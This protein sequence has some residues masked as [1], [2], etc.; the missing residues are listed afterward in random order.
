MLAELGLVGFLL[1]T[2]LLAAT[3]WAL[4]LVARQD[5]ALGVGLAAVLGALV[6]HSLLYAG[7][8]EDPLAWGVIGLAAAALARAPA[9]AAVAE[10]AT[11]TPSS[12]P[13]VLAH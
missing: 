8:F 10:R 12:T 3:G 6:V 7:F 9:A 4:Y 5:R 11:K 13:E 2:W 1:Y